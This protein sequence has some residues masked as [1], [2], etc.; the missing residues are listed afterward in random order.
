MREAWGEQ[1]AREWVDERGCAYLGEKMMSG[2]V[3]ASMTE[4]VDEWVS[5]KGVRG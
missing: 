2:S 4:Q 1:V 3:N 5:K